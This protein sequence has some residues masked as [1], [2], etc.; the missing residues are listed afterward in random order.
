MLLVLDNCD[1]FT[2]NQVR[3]L[4]ALDA[5]PRV[6]HDSATRSPDGGARFLIRAIAVVLAIFVMAGE[7]SAQMVSREGKGDVA[8]DRRLDRF[9]AGDYLLVTT[10]TVIPAGSTVTGNVLVLDSRLT[11]EGRVTG[12]LVGVEANLFLRPSASVDG[13]AVNL[14][15]GLYRSELAAIG[16]VVLDLP[17]IDYGVRRDTDPFARGIDPSARGGD[18]DARGSDHFTIVAARERVPLRLH[19][20]LGFLLP[21]YDRVDAIGLSWA[22]TYRPEPVGAFEPSV[23]GLVRYGSGRG[24]WQG[25]VEAALAHGLTSLAVGVEELTQT[26]EWWI[27]DPLLNTAAVLALG[28]DAR[29]YFEVRRAYVRLDRHLARGRVAGVAQLRGQLER[30]RSLGSGDPWSLLGSAFRPNL[31][32]DDGTIASLLLTLTGGWQGNTA[33]LETLGS[34]EV[35]GRHL[36]GEFDFSRFLLWGDWR[37]DAFRD[38]RLEVEAI[39]RGPLPGTNSLPRQRWSFVG[40]STLPTFATAEFRGDRVVFVETAYVIPLPDRFALPLVGPPDFDIIHAVGMAWTHDTHRRLAQNIGVRLRFI[41][42]YLRIVTDP[43]DPIDSLE[44]GIGVSSPF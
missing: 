42:P 40:G 1:S 38:H 27:R 23:Y 44:I 26:N 14:A 39:F 35:A 30:G 13:D 25:K 15:G 20:L 31:P 3:H 18:H 32:I 24:A 7:A 34:V 29:D 9:L 22:A 8:I 19:G 21:T 37:M 16:G 4:G 33:R 11:L 12:D 43:S 17:L 28:S 6:E 41:S 10:D 2:W 5:E 36:G